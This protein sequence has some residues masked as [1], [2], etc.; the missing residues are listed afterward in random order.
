MFKVRSAH[1]FGNRIYSVPLLSK[2]EIIEHI[3]WENQSAAAKMRS[4][5][6]VRNFKLQEI[7]RPAPPR[8]LRAHAKWLSD[9]ALSDMVAC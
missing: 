7:V 2:Q 5:G 8:S 6:T 3:D 1:V 4:A 9:V